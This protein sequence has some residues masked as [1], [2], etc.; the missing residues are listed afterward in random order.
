MKYN[1]IQK[2]PYKVFNNNDNNSLFDEGLFPLAALMLKK[3]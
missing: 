1:L 3:K 2:Y